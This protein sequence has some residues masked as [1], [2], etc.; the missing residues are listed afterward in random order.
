MLWNIL[1]QKTVSTTEQLLKVILANRK[2]GDID[3]FLNPPSPL[4]ITPKQLKISSTQ[5]KKALAR[6][7]TAIT[8][9]QKVLIYGDYDADGITATSI[10]WLTFIKLGLVAIPFIPDRLK[11]GYGLSIKALKEILDAHQPDL[12]ITVDNGIVANDALE[13]L[14]EQRVDVIVTDHHQPS[15]EKIHALATVH[16]T[17][18]SGATVAWMLAKELSPS[19]AKKLLG[20]VT[21]STIADAMRL[22]DENRSIVKHGLELMRKQQRPGIKA[23]LDVAGINTSEVDVGTIG[24]ALAPR[25]NAAGRIS[26][27][28][29]AV[30]LLCTEDEISAKKIANKLNSLNQQRQDLTSSQLEEADRQA[31]EH[32]E[33]PLIIA[34][35]PTFHEGIIGLLSGR[36]TEKY[37]KPSIVIASGGEVSKASARSVSGVSIT[38]LIRKVE[39]LLLSVGGHE[40]AAGFSVKTSELEKVKNRLLK[41][42]REEIN[43]NLLQPSVKIDAVICANLIKPSTVKKLD[44]LRPLGLGNR[45]PVLMIKQLK[46]DDYR[47]LGKYKEHLKFLLSAVDDDSQAQFEAVGWRMGER[48]EEVQPGEIIDLVGVIEINSWN[49]RQTAQVKIKDFRASLQV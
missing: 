37:F 25:I 2:I 49:G 7:K 17:K 29:M 19:Y 14:K 23:L 4:E 21:I 9:Q 43:A 24:F 40:L 47:S 10:L 46:I 8:T 48:L 33:Q 34:S 22:V 5:L 13:W 15:K 1:N 31:Q 16:S 27:G 45:E 39:E 32:P 35:S 36:L 26:Q 38:N 44:Q 20:L 3:L 11:H 12:I 30:R 41:L 6:I 42:A 28:L 18:V